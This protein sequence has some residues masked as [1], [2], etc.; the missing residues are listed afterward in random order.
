MRDFWGSSDFYVWA[1]SVSSTAWLRLRL[2]STV[3]CRPPF[4]KQRAEDAWVCVWV[5]H[6]HS[7]GFLSLVQS[8]CHFGPDGSVV[9]FRVGCCD[10][11][12]VNLRVLSTVLAIHSLLCSLWLLR[13][14]Y[15]CKERH[16]IWGRTVVLSLFDCLPFPFSIFSVSLLGDL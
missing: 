10:T 14:F 15:L 12:R 3:S 13:F 2:F 9:E 16:L 11:C 5:S 7:L 8:L 1:S 4:N 6:S